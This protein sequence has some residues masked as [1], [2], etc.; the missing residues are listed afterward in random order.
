VGKKSVIE[1]VKLRRRGVKIQFKRVK[2]RGNRTSLT[3][4]RRVSKKALK[5]GILKPGRITLPSVSP[6]SQRG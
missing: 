5:L 3:G 2:V 4:K 6:K 1:K